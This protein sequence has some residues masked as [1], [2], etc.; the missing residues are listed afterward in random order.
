MASPSIALVS[1]QTAHSLPIPNR[2]PS[3]PRHINSVIST[4]M[5]NNEKTY[6][7]FDAKRKVSSDEAS[8][9]STS[10]MSSLKKLLPKKQNTPKDLKRETKEKR[11]RNEAR[12]SYLAN[13]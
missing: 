2:K 7:T 13:R 8:I 1:I 10:T 11:I 4:A 12:A 3:Q 9:R 6:S 5:T